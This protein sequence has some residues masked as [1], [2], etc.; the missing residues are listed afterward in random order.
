MGPVV[1]ALVVALDAHPIDVRWRGEARCPQDGFRDSLER[2]LEGASQRREVG[3]TVEVRRDG[4]ARW[5]A[6]LAVTTADGRSERTLSGRSCAEISDAAA[7]VTAV[8]VDPGVLA[9]P[10]P[11]AIVPEPRAAESAEV[12]SEADSKDMSVAAVP[13]PAGPTGAAEEIP[14]APAQPASPPD[15]LIEAGSATV[16]HNQSPE[17]ASP[18]RLAGFVRVAGGIEALGLP[19]V[20]PQAG[21]AGGVLGRRWRAELT[22]IYRAPTTEFTAIDP[23][24][25]ARVRMWA[26]GARG[27]GVPRAGR[28]EFPLCAGVEVGQTIGQGV[29]FEGARADRFGWAAVV[30][31]PALAWAPRPWLALWL[32]ADLGL[33]LRRGTFGATGL[34]TIFEIG[35]VSL[36]AA[37]GLELRF[38]RANSR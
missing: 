33:P 1:L 22:A 25:G 20:G 5:S 19:R 14:E 7:F 2:Y 12:A 26:V 31:G 34:G 21:L 8:V 11:R 3:V 4:E 10:A 13:G 17:A 15:P 27:C 30:L 29:G 37:L 36:R 38:G 24:A 35:P 23:S 28:V 9:R 18:P 32:G 16:P 6:S